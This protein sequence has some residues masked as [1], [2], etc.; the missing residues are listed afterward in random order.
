[1]SKIEYIVQ[2][3]DGHYNPYDNLNLTLH[4]WTLGCTVLSIPFW[5]APV[6][7]HIWR[8][9]SYGI[10]DYPTVLLGTDDFLYVGMASGLIEKLDLYSNQTIKLYG[11]REALEFGR[12][13]PTPIR[14]LLQFVGEVY[15]ASYGGLYFTSTDE[16]I[17]DRKIGWAGVYDDNLLIVPHGSNAKQLIGVNSSEGGAAFLTFRRHHEESQPGDLISVI[18]AD[19]SRKKKTIMHDIE[20]FDGSGFQPGEHIIA[21]G[22]VYM[23]HGNTHEVITIRRFGSDKL[24][25][26]FGIHSTYGFIEHQGAIYDLRNHK[27]PMIVRSDESGPNSGGKLYIK[28]NDK[29]VHGVVSSGTDGLIICEYDSIKKRSRIISHLFP[30]EPLLESD[31]KLFIFKI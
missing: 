13:I 2:K 1:M 9:G 19:G 12:F 29:S 16:Q 31:G 23:H 24:V 15:D 30:D 28:P 7:E 4:T 11:P 27:E 26:I 17:D 6:G 25:H 22:M 14:Y 21:D 3:D 8:K 5:K 20:P 10:T 18:S